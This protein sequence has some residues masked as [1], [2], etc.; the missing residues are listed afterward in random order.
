MLEQEEDILEGF[1]DSSSDDSDTVTK[2][3]QKSKYL[4]DEE[5]SRVVSAVRKI[6]AKYQADDFQTY[7]A[8]TPVVTHFLKRSMMRDMRKFMALAI[9]TVA[10][11]L[12][13]TFRRITGVILPLITVLLSLLSTLGIMSIAGAAIK[14]PTQILPSFLLAV[15]VGTSVHI[16][17]ICFHRFQQNGDKE[18]SI[19]YALGHSGL[20]VVMTNVTTASGLLSFST[21]EVAPIADVGVFAGI[22]V[23]LAFIYT[24][25]LLP[26]LLAVVPLA[27]KGSNNPHQKDTL[28]ERFLLGVSSFSR[29]S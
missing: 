24:I 14:I 3:P 20:A 10:V 29:P 26:A 5:N 12:F 16:L 22:G 4:T 2:A 6:V 9:G 11:L 23:L 18:A 17:A 1:E 25:V 19:A 27:D 13:M 28:M 15:G 8:G 21:S 7:I